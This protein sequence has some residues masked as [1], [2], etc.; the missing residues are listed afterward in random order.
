VLLNAIL[1]DQWV[2]ARAS[3]NAVDVTN[4]L[5][6]IKDS[7]LCGDFNAILDDQWVPAHPSPSVVDVTHCLLFSGTAL[8]VDVNAILDIQWVPAHASQYA[9][10]F[11]SCSL[12]HAWPVEVSMP[13]SRRD[14]NPNVNFSTRK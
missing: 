4:C 14:V 2:P 8:P 3:P 6:F 7:S 12:E 9:V 1:D 11:T 10:D 13:M 5:V